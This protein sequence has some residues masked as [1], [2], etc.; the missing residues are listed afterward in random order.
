MRSK[1][2]RLVIITAGGSRKS[3]GVLVGGVFI[4]YKYLEMKRFEREF[5]II[6]QDK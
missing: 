2:G 1:I 4:G 5:K 3:S 6:V